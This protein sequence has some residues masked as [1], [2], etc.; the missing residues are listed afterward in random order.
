MTKIEALRAKL[1]ASANR[2]IDPDA[3]PFNHSLYYGGM[4]AY[5]VIFSPFLGFIRD[6]EQHS[7]P[8]PHLMIEP[9]DYLIKRQSPEGYPFGKYV[10]DDDFLNPL[11]MS[12]QGELEAILSDATFYE[13]DVMEDATNLLIRFKAK[14]ARDDFFDRIG[15]LSHVYALGYDAWVVLLDEDEHFNAGWKVEGNTVVFEDAND[16]MIFNVKCHGIKTRHE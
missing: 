1:Q 3:E 15:D 4:D 12:D 7:I 9:T 6:E 14:E 11:F 2:G 10:E 13:L 16:E 8:Y 5:P